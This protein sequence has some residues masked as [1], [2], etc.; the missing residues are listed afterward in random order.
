MEESSA[1]AAQGKQWFDST[2]WTGLR[3]PRPRRLLI[4]A[5][6]KDGH[7]NYRT[8]AMAPH[9]VPEF[10]DG[11]TASPNIREARIY[12]EYFRLHKTFA[13]DLDPANFKARMDGMLAVLAAETP[14]RVGAPP[15]SL[16]PPSV[17]K[18]EE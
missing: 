1:P 13:E 16:N 4:A 5:T 2:A 8:V 17:S 14:A 9:L 18:G 11:L 12:D 6:L 15:P 3:K 10:I 7:T